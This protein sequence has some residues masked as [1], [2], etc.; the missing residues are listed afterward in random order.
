MR[1]HGRFGHKGSCCDA[2]DEC[3]LCGNRW[4]RSGASERAARS[5]NRAL[6]SIIGLR[7]ALA[8]LG[9]NFH[10]WMAMSCSLPSDRGLGPPF[11]SPLARDMRRVLDPTPRSLLAG[12]VHKSCPG[13]PTETGARCRPRPPTLA[14]FCLDQHRWSAGRNLGPSW[15]PAS[16]TQVKRGGPWTVRPKPSPREA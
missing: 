1:A 11:S 12:C 2:G 4:L 8:R 13:V 3:T 16:G 5:A 7:W 14:V 10:R 6:R 9:A 15:W